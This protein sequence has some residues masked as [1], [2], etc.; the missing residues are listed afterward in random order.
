MNLSDVKIMSERLNLDIGKYDYDFDVFVNDIS[1]KI[2]KIKDTKKIGQ[3]IVAVD[4][5]DIEDEDYLGNNRIWPIKISAACIDKS[6]FD[7]L[8]KNI[9]SYL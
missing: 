9:I 3:V 6:A 4:Y 5:Q 8:I 2:D 1:A 7:T